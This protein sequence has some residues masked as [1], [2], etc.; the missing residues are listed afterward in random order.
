MNIFGDFGDERSLD[1]MINE[2]NSKLKKIGFKPINF[3][4]SFSSESGVGVD[5]E[6]SKT[7][8]T[9]EDGTTKIIT[10]T[11]GFGSPDKK[12]KVSNSND[13]LFLEKELKKAIDKQEFELAVE[14]RDAIKKIKSETEELKSLESSLKD[15]IKS[16]NFELCIE[17]RNKINKIKNL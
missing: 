7:T 3:G 6:W 9:S 13:L 10:M 12:S 17:L 4:S 1:D 11:S 16:Q 15:A 8:Y 5:G 2:L 14:I